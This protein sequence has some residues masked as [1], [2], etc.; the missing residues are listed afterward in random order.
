MAG[1]DRLADGYLP[2]T[3]LLFFN[4]NDANESYESISSKN[5]RSLEGK[6]QLM[7]EQDSSL[8]PL[9]VAHSTV[10]ENNPLDQFKKNPPQALF[11][12]TRVSVFVH[13]HICYLLSRLD[14]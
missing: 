5:R 6:Q 4:W 14:W 8:T 9:G 7:N 11:L 10:L 1:F 12:H 2:N 13:E 3:Q